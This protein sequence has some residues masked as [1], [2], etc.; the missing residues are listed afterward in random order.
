MATTGTGS[1]WSVTPTYD[2]VMTPARGSIPI[3][4]SCCVGV[5][6]LVANG[7]VLVVLLGYGRLR[8]RPSAMLVVHQTVT[9]AIC[10]AFLLLVNIIYFA[11][12][13]KLKDTWGDFVCRVLV[14]ELLF[15]IAFTASSLSL[16]SIT[17]ERYLVVVHPV[18]HRNHFTKRMVVLSVVLNWVFAVIFLVPLVLIFKVEHGLCVVSIKGLGSLYNYFVISGF[19]GVYLLPC[20]FLIFGYGRMVWVLLKRNKVVTV[21]ITNK[22]R[23][24]RNQMNTTTTMVVIAVVFFI[25]LTPFQLYM[26][27]VAFGEVERSKPP[28]NIY[29]CLLVLSLLNCCI[30]PFIYAVKYNTFKTGF[31]RLF[32]LKTDTAGDTTA[33]TIL[34]QE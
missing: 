29:D 25:C 9:D 5:L 30:N 13:G 34:S 31:R 2:D 3:I 17:L 22:N 32:N 11:L 4:T 21:G 28:I 1:V 24:S 8:Y 14:N 7:F 6:G 18:F 15:W 12:E 26:I 19:L 33:I 20:L 16:V 27:M 10:S 23:M